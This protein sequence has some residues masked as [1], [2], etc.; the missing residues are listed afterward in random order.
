M[1]RQIMY[2]PTHTTDGRMGRLRRHIIAGPAI[3]ITAKSRRR[4]HVATCFVTSTCCLERFP[5]DPRVLNWMQMHF[6]GRYE[7]RTLSCL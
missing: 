5:P 2:P 1:A 7:R 4:R 3:K 6:Y